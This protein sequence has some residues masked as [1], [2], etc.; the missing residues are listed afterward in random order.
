MTMLLNYTVF[1]N[2][3]NIYNTQTNIYIIECILLKS[4]API[5][6]TSKA[7]YNK[8]TQ[9]GVKRNWREIDKARIFT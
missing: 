7:N 3:I 2:I 8:S 6:F 5:D 4:Y 9:M 1:I